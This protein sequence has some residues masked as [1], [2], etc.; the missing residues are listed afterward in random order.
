[1]WSVHSPHCAPLLASLQLFPL[2]SAFYTFTLGREIAGRAERILIVVNVQI[3]IAV[4]C[5]FIPLQIRR[6]PA[7]WLLLISSPPFVHSVHCG[8]TCTQ[9]T[10]KD[11]QSTRL[12]FSFFFWFKVS[13][14]CY[15]GFI[16]VA[17]SSPLSNPCLLV[18]Y[19]IME[20]PSA[21]TQLTDNP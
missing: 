6:P 2:L 16:G 11:T 8:A 7:M 18:D 12:H 9:H 17:I 4:Y 19:V 1:M 13:L 10:R 15:V 21:N 14:L 3:L 5:R 20:Q